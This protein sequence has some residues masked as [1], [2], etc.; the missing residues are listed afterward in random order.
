MEKNIKL[1]IEY[2]GT[3]YHGFQ[4][5]PDVKTIQ[6]EIERCLSL[7]FQKTIKIYGAG[8][9]DAGVHALEQV[10]N[11]KHSTDKSTGLLHRALNGLLS[12]DIIIRSVEEVPLDFHSRYSARNRTYQYTILNRPYSGVFFRDFVYFYRYSLD[13]EAMN[14]AAGM[15][16]GTHDF[17]SFCVKSDDEKNY[18]RTLVRFKCWRSGDL[19]ISEIEADGFLHMMVRILMG[20]L[21]Q[22]G[23]G[24]YS[25]ERLGDILKAKDRRQAGPTL[26]A[27]GLCL[28]RVGY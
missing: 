9:T 27:R 23:R 20:T 18:T 3:N 17:S 2:D 28:I 15:F 19:L 5:Q 4:I 13:V 25:F 1:T 14:R 26:P 12:E 6:G 11:F 7:I 22:V 21:V 10:A 24:K 8:R 16:V